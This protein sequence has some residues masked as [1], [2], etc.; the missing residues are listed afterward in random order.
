MMDMK[1]F[2]IKN[3]NRFILISLRELKLKNIISCCLL[4]VSII[5]KSQTTVFSEN[6]NVSKGSS[7]SNI[8]GAIG[9]STIWNMM[10]SG[11]DWGAKIDANYLDLTNDADTISN[12]NGYVF[13]YTPL[14]NF[15]AP[16]NAILSANAGIINWSFNFRTNRTT[17]LS[18]FNSNTY[19]IAMVLVATSN[20]PDTL[21]SGYAV[22]MGGGTSN[23]IAL[24]YFTGGLKG[25]KTIIVNYGGDTLKTLNNSMSIQASYN[26]SN[27]LWSL[28]NRDDGSSIF[29]DPLTGVFTTVGSGINS[30]G[31][32]TSMTYFGAYWQGSTAANQKC[33]IDNITVSEIVYTH[34]YSKFTGNLNDLSNWGSNTDGTGANPSDFTIVNQVF[35]IRNNA[36]PTI[37]AAWVVSGTNS[38]IIVGN[39]TNA[40][41]FT[42]PS[43]FS[44]TGIIDVANSGILT[45]QNAI[46]PIFGTLA[47]T[48]TII[49]DGAM[50]QTINVGTYANLTIQN[51]GATKLLGGNI[52][53]G[54]SNTFTLAV[55]VI[56]NAGTNLLSFGT[57]GNAFI[58]GV[59]QTAN[60]AGFSGT[61]VT[62][63][64]NLNTPTITIGSTS[65]IVYNSALLQNI[66][67][68]T[69]ANI[70]IS[71][72]ASAKNAL[73]DLTLG[74][75]NTFT[76]DAGVTYNANTYN[77]KFGTIGTVNI[78]GIFQ[79]A[80]TFSGGFSGGLNSAIVNTNTP[81]INLNSGS[82]VEYS[83]ASTQKIS[84]ANS[85]GSNGTLTYYH[86]L[87]SGITGTKTFNVNPKIAAGGIFTVNSNC[88][89]DFVTSAMDF[90]V[91]CSTTI[92]GTV[93]TQKVD[94]GISGISSSVLNATNS[95][96]I[97]FGVN[98]TIVYNGTGA[99]Q[100]V[101][102]VNY[103]NLTIAGSGNKNL[104]GNVTV[105]GMLLLSN[106]LIVGSNTLTLNGAFSGSI[107]NSLTGSASSNLV[108]TGAAKTLFFDQTTSVTNSMKN[109][110]ISGVNT[111]TLG[112]GLNIIASSAF[113]TV[114]VGAGATLA[115]VGNL[116]LKS[117][118]SGTACILN[119]AGAISGNANVERFISSAG[120]R[121]RFL[122][123]PVQSQTIANWMTQFYV[124][125]PCTIAPSA[126]GVIN[127][128]GWHSS[129]NNISNPGV[130]HASTN[131]NAVRYTSIRIYDETVIG[132]LDN[133]FSDVL[134]STILSP[135]KGF[136]AFIRGP[137]G[138]GTGQL[139]G[140]VASQ[141]A[142]TLSLTGIPNQGDVNAL[143]T[144]TSTSTAAND[145]WNL[146]GNPYPCGYNL[147]TQYDSAQSS[148]FSNVNT[149]MHIYNAASGGYNSYNANGGVA[150][151][152]FKFG[153]VPSGSAFF[154]QVTSSPIF[155]FKEK[156]KTSTA[157]G[158]ILH[159]TVNTNEF[160][161]IYSKDSSE[162][163]YLTVK[164][165][166]NAALNYD[167]F[168]IKKLRNENLNLAA[169]GLD[170]IDL[171]ASV[172][173]PIN[174]ET[175][176][177]LNVE[178]NLIG[179]YQFEFTNMDNFDAGVS[180]NLIDKYTNKVTNV[181][182]N[183]KYEFD[184]GAAENQWGKTRFELILNGKT[185]SSVDE[186]TAI[187]KSFS[188]YPNPATHLLN[189]SINNVC[190][191]NAKV[192]IYN[193]SGQQIMNSNMN[194]N[195]IQLN[196]ESLSKGI[197]FVNIINE[198]G[199]NKSVKFVK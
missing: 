33:F 137:I 72:G 193:I 178:A 96:T 154:I 99:N 134:T 162:S 183:T 73:A 117:D 83:S 80:N 79:T 54:N 196:I 182:V 91:G 167:A 38:K 142:L 94:G 45:L 111:M 2:F 46:Y 13:G 1:M 173:S 49:Y 74:I 58:N 195:N 168:D 63:I 70:Q 81:T 95:P 100:T 164:I 44:V 145:G 10:K 171:A 50:S 148:N 149:T 116:T 51:N 36:T 76:L 9:T 23:N 88:F 197:Y 184:M 64:S 42:I 152:N 185:S 161:I 101:S 131:S 85:S 52:V 112:N 20:T 156:F 127:D 35:N 190:N 121:Y 187:F 119:S 177:K 40:C 125:G 108:L 109:L 92:L 43:S 151:G 192:S 165:Y 25:T 155:I 97:S 15:S 66:T 146:I 140:S 75:S 84:T 82:T 198:N 87:I 3:L 135:G 55:G 126:L 71:N 141:D 39:G 16:Y 139:N 166:D 180:V 144:F 67:G 59:L 105:G 113:G 32:N 30:T 186:N 147:K 153:I 17:V 89:V 69:F 77:M 14:S 133:G 107:A 124:T 104:N 34:F 188:V 169:F 6:F 57:N 28:S 60:T 53:I 199:F 5:V 123:S 27:N 29:V 132:S 4:I 61:T 56:L 189:I 118:A 158:G 129:Q 48:S 62:T 181:K 130:Y 114:T 175:R 98:S 7:Y 191:N 12:V 143:P 159:K 8:T 128:Q 150:N 157:P 179:K 163:D 115:T 174:G 11:S 136:K 106:K 41:N 160:E 102:P 21:G 90:G 103:A 26:P 110:S 120:R 176:I 68:G 31:V 93:I 65:T 78:N 18:G 86:L 122:S 22:I 172:I 170:L 19:G 47:S 138:I 24:I 37:N 194:S